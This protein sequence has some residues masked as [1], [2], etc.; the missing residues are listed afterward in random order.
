MASGFG[1]DIAAVTTVPTTGNTVT[2]GSGLSIN[3]GTVL[4]SVLNGDTPYSANYPASGYPD[5]DLPLISLGSGGTMGDQNATQ[6]TNTYSYGS[7]GTWALKDVG[8]ILNTPANDSTG[9][10]Y[11]M[12]WTVTTTVSLGQAIKSNSM[13]TRYG[14]RASHRETIAS[15]FTSMPVSRPP[16]H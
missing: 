12:T 16:S 14:C 15:P 4:G 5:T 8:T 9:D 3:S 13:P 1:E 7:G 10:E 6:Q 2:A 11:D